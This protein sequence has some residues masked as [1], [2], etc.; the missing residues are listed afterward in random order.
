MPPYNGLPTF[1]Q[2][3]VQIET[4]RDLLIKIDLEHLSELFESENI[5]LYV[6]SEMTHDDL[7]SV[8]VTTFGWRHKILKSFA[9]EKPQNVIESIVTELFCENCGKTFTKKG[10]S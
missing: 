2:S 7:K 3:S 8:G 6:L 1:G 4:V 10:R 9:L 5:D